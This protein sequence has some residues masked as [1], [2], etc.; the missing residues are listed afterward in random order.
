MAMTNRPISTLALRQRLLVA[1]GRSTLS[2][3]VTGLVACS[4]A[5][6]SGGTGGGGQSSAE[7]GTVTSGE[8]SSQAAT[9][10]AS[11]ETTAA[12]GTGSGGAAG[13]GGAGGAGGTGGAG[14]ALGTG[15]SGGQV[16]TGGASTTSSGGEST[17]SSGTEVYRCFSW[18]IDTPCPGKA[19]DQWKC[20]ETNE[21]IE[22]QVSGPV[23]EN[24][25]CCY[26][27]VVS[28]GCIVVGRPFTVD[29]CLV[30]SSLERRDDWCAPSAEPADDS[31]LTAGERRRLADMWSEAGLFEH[32]SVASFGRFA[33]EL[34]A[35]GAPADLIRGAHEAALDEV[36]HAELSFALASRFAGEVRGPS[37]FP[38]NHGAS[39]R[40]DV[41]SIIAA[42]AIEG[43]VHETVAALVAMAQRDASTDPAVRAAL[44][45]IAEDESRHAELAFRTLR[46][47]S[48]TGESSAVRCALR[49]AMRE[50]QVLLARER[51]AVATADASQDGARLGAYGSLEVAELARVKVAALEGVV[52]PCL[53][54]LLAGCA[55]SEVEDAAAAPAFQA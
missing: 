21:Q 47:A 53:G 54:A 13:V 5:A 42:T 45:E 46:W 20:T 43:C 36:R 3:A 29:S 18:T 11:G 12:S 40:S 10:S 39:I 22:G 51:A 7:T 55:T 49:A 30:V 2:I 4:D 38:A 50:A 34:M 27:L 9:S 37:R 19:I 25:Q 48:T 24:G 33:L 31:R 44:T 35:L 26:T 52:L 1:A 32:A 14:G 6:S 15:G 17:G 28:D 16:G 8:S 41:G 23:A